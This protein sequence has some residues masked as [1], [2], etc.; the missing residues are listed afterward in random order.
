M[1]VEK[2]LLRFDLAPTIDMAMSLLDGEATARVLPDSG[3]DVSVAGK[4]LLNHL[5]EH[6]DN[7]LLPSNVMP[8]RCSPLANLQ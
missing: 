8:P 4:L 6:Q 5:R 1:H 7:S 2:T 3:A